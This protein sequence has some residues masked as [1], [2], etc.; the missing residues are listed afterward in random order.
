MRP[1][2]SIVDFTNLSKWASCSA[3]FALMICFS[4]LASTLAV[5]PY[6]AA[7]VCKA[8]TIA[9]ERDPDTAR[10]LRRNVAIN[11]LSTLADVRQWALGG[12]HGQIAFTVGLDTMNRVARPDDKSA[13]VVPIRRLDDI[14]DAAAPTLIKLDVEGFEE[15]VLSGASRVLGSPSL[16]AVQSELCSPI[17]QNTLQSFGLKLRFYDP[18]TRALR[19]AAFGYRTSNA[20]FVRDDE[21]VRERLVHAP[22]RIVG[23]KAL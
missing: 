7:K 15:Q 17:V 1:A 3:F 9:F 4:M 8:R 22:S 14:H 18:F 21:V 19:P 16:L 6:L 5:T 10:A 13:Q 11:R 2:T 23:S 20:L 12:V